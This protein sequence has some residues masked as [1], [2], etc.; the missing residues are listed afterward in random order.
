MSKPLM[1]P[2]MEL[3]LIFALSTA[4]TVGAMFAGTCRQRPIILCK[5]LSGRVVVGPY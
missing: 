5:T 4:F 1:R 3:V 2:Q